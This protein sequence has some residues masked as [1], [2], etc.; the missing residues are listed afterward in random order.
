MRDTLP[1]Q[2]CMR[3]KDINLR[4]GMNCSEDKM[5]GRIGGCAKKKMA[6]KVYKNQIEKKGCITDPGPLAVKAIFPCS[7]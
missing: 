7:I 6:G 2:I 1:K 3:K 5:V 4:D